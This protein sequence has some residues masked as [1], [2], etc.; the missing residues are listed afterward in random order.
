MPSTSPQVASILQSTLVDLID[1]SLIGKQ[2][3]W[4]V[5]GP[6][7]RSVHL[8]LDEVVSDVRLWSDTVAERLAQLGVSPDGRADTV[9]STSQVDDIGAGPIGADK[10]VQLLSERLDAASQN[11][12]DAL[13]EL[14]EDL[15]SQDHLIAIGQ[16]LD[17][18]AWFLRSQ[19]K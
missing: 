4:N 6:Q 3:H 5:H 15:L 13:P 2:A 9:A 11:I 1:L 17:K 19:I 18:H 7:F 16:G 12:K 8:E 10:V 14:E